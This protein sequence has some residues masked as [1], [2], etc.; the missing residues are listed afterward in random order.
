MEDTNPAGPWVFEDS[1]SVQ[2]EQ[3][4]D[5]SEVEFVDGHGIFVHENTATIVE[6]EQSDSASV[7]VHC[8]QL[9][10]EKTAETSF[11]RQFFWDINK[12]ADQTELTLSPGEQFLVNYLVTVN[13]TGSV[14]SDWAVEGTISVHNPNPESGAEINNINDVISPDLVATVD[15]GVEFP[16]ELAPEATLECTYSSELPDDS[17]RVNTATTVLQ[18]HDYNAD[19]VAT[20]SGTTEYS[21]MADVVFGD[22]SELIDEMIAVSD[23]FAG[24]LGTVSFDNA[25]MVFEYER[26]IGPYTVDDCGQTTVDNTAEFVSNDTQ[27]VGSDDH[28]ILVDVLCG[29]TL[30]QG[31]WKTHSEFGPAPYD[32]TWAELPDGASTTFFLS[33]QTYYEVMGTPVKGN[34]YYNLAHQYIAAVLNGLAGA[35]A[36][37]EVASA[38][39]D[40]EDLFN[41][42]TPA[43]TAG[44]KGNQGERQE[45]LELASILAAYN[46]GE[47]G[48]GHC[49]EESI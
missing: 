46:E 25:P 20:E 45:F 23:S 47:I 34:V 9:G 13:V 40:A 49:T 14:D 26:T 29:C 19:G 43:Q 15:C 32:E 8:Y 17:Q 42:Y 3:T 24:D 4:F 35:P 18:N 37:A 36:P 48:P 16:Y 21:G 28:N 12:T 2:Y 10:V 1:G 6:T 41:T 31:Y 44:W 7:T 33:G 30:T 39:A 5:C 38:I 27:A 22:P 11:G